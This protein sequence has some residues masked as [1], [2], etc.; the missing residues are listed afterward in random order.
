MTE[1]DAPEAWPVLAPE[2]RLAGL[3]KKTF[4]HCYIQTMKALGLVVSEQLPFV[5]LWE[6]M[7]PGA[8]PVWTPGVWLAGFIKMTSIHCYIQ[9]MKALGHVVSEKKVFYV[10]P[11]THQGRGMYGPHRHD[12]QDL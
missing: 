10:F 9:N 3:I 12:W 4:I 8:G 1:N 2:A 5:S 7:T 11:M 6:L